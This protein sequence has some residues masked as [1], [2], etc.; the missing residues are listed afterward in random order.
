MAQKQEVIL[1]KLK[2]NNFGL[3]HGPSWNMI[4]QLALTKDSL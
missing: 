2:T 4:K 3:P 1:R